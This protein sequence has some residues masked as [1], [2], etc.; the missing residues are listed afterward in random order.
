MTEIERRLNKRI[1]FIAEVSLGR[2]SEE[3]QCE[4]H[5]ISLKGM[6]VVVPEGIQSEINDDFSVYLKL[7]DDADI[8]MA[9]RLIHSQGLSWGMAWQ[10]IELEGFTHLRRLL[11]LNINDPV[12]LSREIA[13]LA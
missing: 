6:L 4:L 13:D 11:E 1:P 8:K 5:D 7:S 12:A 2:G 3:W 9:A 10:N